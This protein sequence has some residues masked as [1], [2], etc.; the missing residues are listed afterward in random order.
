[1]AEIE[2][3]PE[4]G[5]KLENGTCS[6][7]QARHCQRISK[8]NNA[9]LYDTL[10]NHTTTARTHNQIRGKTKHMYNLILVLFKLGKNTENATMSSL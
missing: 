4:H 2:G 8:S 1:M 10:A 7:V 6:S 3:A 9:N 5:S